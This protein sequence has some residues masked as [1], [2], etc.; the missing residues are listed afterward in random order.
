MLKHRLLFGAV[1]IAGLVGLFYADDALSD[2]AW[3]QDAPGI[4]QD[5]GMARCD[6]LLVAVVL[7]LLVA[8]GTRELG[9]LFAAAG[10]APLRCWPVLVNVVLVLIPFVAANGPAGEGDGLHAADTSWTMIALV[11]GFIGVAAFVAGRRRTDGAIAAIG[12]SMFMIVYL[13]LLPQFIV[14]IRV[15]G[16]TGATWLLLY[17]L[18][19]VKFCDIGAYFT[20]RAIGRTKL[21]AWLS[22]GKTI[23]GLFGGIAASVV[24]A[25]AIPM[26][27]GSL[28]GPDSPTRGLF[29]DLG[30]AALFGLMMA[31][32]GQAGDL[33]ESLIKRDAQVKDSAGVIPAFG[34]VL[35]ILDSPLLTAPIAYAF[36]VH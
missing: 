19:A 18:A 15:F 4:L 29:P 3:S 22:P 27:V 2:M 34:G 16:P 32:V 12:A 20:G 33:L 28:A 24:F 1:L 14:R 26:L 7:V 30:A 13:G 6:G 21:I 8:L 10:N 36:L 35:D 9:V 5:I 31:V 23:E 17:Y 25:V 11:V